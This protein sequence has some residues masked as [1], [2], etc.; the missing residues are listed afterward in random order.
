MAGMPS[1][2]MFISV[3]QKTG[4]KPTVVTISPGRPSSSALS[5]ADLADIVRDEIVRALRGG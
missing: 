4:F 2:V 5:N 1:C 3:P